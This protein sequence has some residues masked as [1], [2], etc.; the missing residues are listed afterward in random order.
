MGR[1]QSRKT[2]YIGRF[3]LFHSADSIKTLAS[4][5]K[6][7]PN[8][9][10]FLIQVNIGDESTKAGIGKEHLPKFIGDYLSAGLTKT[11]LCGIMVIPP[12]PAVPEDSR[13][14]FREAREL[15]LS[16]KERF[17]EELPYFSDLSMGMSD[18]YEVAIEE[19]ATILRIGRAIFGGRH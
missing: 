11:R 4:I 18:D 15:F 19:G 7:A 9:V 1:L 13:Q 2:G 5:E 8:A 6:K 3:D 14:Y 16:V 10:D 12:P 17:G